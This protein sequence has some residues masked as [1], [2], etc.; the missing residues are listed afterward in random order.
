[1]FMKIIIKWKFFWKTSLK[2]K[3]N[4]KVI[5]KITKKYD[6]VLAA[7]VVEHIKDDKKIIQNFYDFLKK[8]GH[9]LITVPAFNFLYSHKD[10]ALKHFRR[11]RRSNIKKL[12]IKRFQIKKL[13]YFNFLL[14]LPIALSILIFKIKNTKFIKFV[15]TTP[16]NWINTIFKNI[17]L[18]EKY[19]LKFLNFPF[20]IS[21]I[22]LAKKN[23]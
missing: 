2:K 22:A 5:N 20:G 11:Y 15:E 17:F 3:N 23:D 12:L 14:F 16:T 8:D 21:I 18:I 10:I 4:V 6:L 13:S 7:D 1:M 9:I 19:L